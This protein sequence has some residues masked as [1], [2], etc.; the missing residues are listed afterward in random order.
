M[1]CSVIYYEDNSKAPRI[2]GF[3]SVENAKIWLDEEK[4]KYTAGNLNAQI[5]VDYTAVEA[6]R[7][8]Y[9]LMRDSVFGNEKERAQKGKKVVI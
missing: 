8:M 7:E 1:I 3:S 6:Y 9:E 4:T 2:K 5:V